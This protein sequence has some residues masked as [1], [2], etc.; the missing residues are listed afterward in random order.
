M[1]EWGDDSMHVP[2]LPAPANEAPASMRWLRGGVGLLFLV[3]ALWLVH[4]T[5]PGALYARFAHLRLE[6]VGIAMLIAVP[7]WVFL[8][9]RWRLTSQ[10]L[11]V[12]LT[13]RAALHA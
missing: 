7:Q 2:A 13:P 11:G 9:W 1:Q 8:A 6:Y 4:R 12:P 5:A 3:G 10:C